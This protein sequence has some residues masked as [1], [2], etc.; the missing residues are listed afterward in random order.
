MAAEPKSRQ[1]ISIA[2]RNGVVYID[3]P[4]AA[5]H[6]RARGDAFPDGRRKAWAMGPSDG[7]RLA[8]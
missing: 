6:Q 4:R 5:G 1:N 8:A 7:N 2:S 3:W